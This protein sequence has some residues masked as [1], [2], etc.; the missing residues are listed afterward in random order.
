MERAERRQTGVLRRTQ[1]RQSDREDDEAVVH[2]SQGQGGQDLPL[3]GPR[4]DKAKNAG[5]PTRSLRVTIPKPRPA[6]PTTNPIPAIAPVANTPA[7]PTP[8]SPTPDAP[9]PEPTPYGQTTLTEAMVD[10]LFWR[11]GFGPTQ[12]RP[13]HLDGQDGRRARRLLRQH[14][15][16][17]AAGRRRQADRRPAG[18]LHGLL[19][20][21]RAAAEGQHRRPG[22]P[23]RLRHRA[24]AR[25]DRPD[26]A[27]GQPAA[28][29]AR[30]LLAPP[31]G[32]QP[33]G[34]PRQPP[35][36]AIPQPAAAL[37]RPRPHPDR[38]VP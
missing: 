22:R 20:R 9:A 28:G 25:V 33:R 36:P 4:Y 21:A 11:A 27:R 18:P 38:D 32:G 26:A 30:V 16:R 10:R 6:A 31:L 35:D 37:R 1:G 24:R 2:G 3:R 8:D 29:P 34:R 5:A 13:H 12:A 15:R 17:G 23:Q 19:R 7:A 14:A